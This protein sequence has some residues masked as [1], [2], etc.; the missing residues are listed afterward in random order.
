MK[1]Y[2]LHI[3][4]HKTGSNFIQKNI[5]EKISSEE[6]YIITPSSKINQTILDFL[7]IKNPKLKKKIFLYLKKIEKKKIIYSSEALFIFMNGLRIRS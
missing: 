5:L 1:Q 4:F 6:Y 3:G 2:Y 7:K